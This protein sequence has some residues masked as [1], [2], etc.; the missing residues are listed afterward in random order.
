MTY[1][2]TVHARFTKSSEIATFLNNELTSYYDSAININENKKNIESKKNEVI[3]DGDYQIYKCDL[4][5][6]DEQLANNAYNILNNNF[7]SAVNFVD[8]LEE[9]SSYIELHNCYNDEVPGRPCEVVYKRL[10]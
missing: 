4:P 5:L 3:D 10:S 8:D 2:V 9:R 7:D 6:T 1:R